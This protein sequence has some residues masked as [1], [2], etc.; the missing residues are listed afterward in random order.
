MII[1]LLPAPVAPITIIT[2]PGAG[3]QG[4]TVP[5]SHREI[6]LSVVGILFNFKAKISGY[7]CVAG[8]ISVDLAFI[9]SAK[10]RCFGGGLTVA[11]ASSNSVGLCLSYKNSGNCGSEN[12]ATE[13]VGVKS[14]NALQL[15]FQRLQL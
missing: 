3:W 15:P 1:V 4:F 13:K 5:I 10:L 14:C 2:L 8:C 9:S 12:F 11:V 7:P 6:C